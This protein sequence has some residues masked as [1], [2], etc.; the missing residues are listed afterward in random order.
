MSKKRW[1]SVVKVPITFELIFNE[2][3]FLHVAHQFFISEAAGPPTNWDWRGLFSI[4]R[5]SVSITGWFYQVWHTRKFESLAL[6]EEMR[7][8]FYLVLLAR[9]AGSLYS[10]V[11]QL[12]L[13]KSK[14]KFCLGEYFR[15]V[16]AQYWG[17]IKKARKRQKKRKYW[18]RNSE[19]V[20]VL[21]STDLLMKKHF[22]K[23]M[24]II[25]KSSLCPT[26]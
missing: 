20:A 22:G 24:Q 23:Y 10:S 8:L 25:T 14:T 6:G 16:E 2:S 15:V 1:K 18:K 3:I 5:T 4:L 13:S 12:M 9:R 7:S 21:F 17:P 26:N 19:K 11:Y